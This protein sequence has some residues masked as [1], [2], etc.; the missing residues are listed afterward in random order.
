[1]SKNG[2]RMSKSELDFK[3]NRMFKNEDGRVSEN[4]RGSFIV[5]KCEVG[6][7][8]YVSF[9]WNIRDEIFCNVDELDEVIIYLVENGYE[10]YHSEDINVYV[11]A[12]D[13]KYY[14][15]YR[16]NL[17]GPVLNKED[18]IKNVVDYISV[19]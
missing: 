1:M 6:E 13:N 5:G 9:G 15:K 10:A 16:S 11:N 2:I 4:E 17:P 3:M 18:A 7:L 8:M 14:L 19:L 12:T